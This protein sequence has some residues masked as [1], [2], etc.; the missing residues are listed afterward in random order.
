MMNSQ[1]STSSQLKSTLEISNQPSFSCKVFQLAII[2]IIPIFLVITGILAYQNMQA[3]RVI[4][5]LASEINELEK[6]VE[7]S[8]EPTHSDQPSS[9]NAQP[10]KTRTEPITL[11]VSPTQYPTVGWATYKSEEYGFEI[12]Y[13]SSFTISQSDGSIYIGSEEKSGAEGPPGALISTKLLQIKIDGLRQNESIHTIAQT[14]A[15]PTEAAVSLDGATVQ[16]IEKRSSEYIP[17]FYTTRRFDL[18]GGRQEYAIFP[19]SP[20][21][22]KYMSI[23]AKRWDG[24]SYEMFY[25]ILSTV[26]FNR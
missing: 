22:S 19:Y 24:R 15:T 1:S 21:A 18:I 25:G 23:V 2:I 14:I 12:S 7:V 16:S 13:P 26:R 17:E 8:V 9:I 4:E 20:D 3:Q 11:V 6:T 5:D 10:S